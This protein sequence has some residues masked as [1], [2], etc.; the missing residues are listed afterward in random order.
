MARFYIRLLLF[1]FCCF[2]VGADLEFGAARRERS[3][4][5]LAAETERMKWDAL[6][7][8]PCSLARTVAV[9]GDRW[10]LMILRECFLR[11]R[12]FEAFQ[13]SLGITRHLL[14][15]RLKKLVRFGVLRRIPYMESP[16]RYE[17]ILTQKGLDLYPIVMSIVHWGNVHM[18]DSRGKPLLHEH[19]NCGKMFDPI[20]VCSECGG[21]L[22]AKEV[23]VHPGPGL[24]S[25]TVAERPKKAVKK[26]PS[27]RAA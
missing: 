14:A 3:S 21:P 9:I 20:M 16:K 17:Y 2:R 25:A 7:E 27:E 8:E 5:G 10:S 1:I 18:V 15:E 12:R 11:K 6:E 24:I 23:H 13:S 26:K 22:N 4:D 19:K